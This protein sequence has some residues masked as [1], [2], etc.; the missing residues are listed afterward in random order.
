MR[1]P[2]PEYTPYPH[3]REE[4]DWRGGLTTMR[5]WDPEGP[6]LFNMCPVAFDGKSIVPFVLSQ[7]PDRGKKGGRLKKKKKSG[8]AV[9]AGLGT[10]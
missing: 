10:L 4:P 9:V 3:P 1:S 5:K 8:G 6:D 7:R 2:E